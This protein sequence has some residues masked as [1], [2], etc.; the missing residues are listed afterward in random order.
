MLRIDMAATPS[1]I[2]EECAAA[3]SRSRVWRCVSFRVS[4]MGSFSNQRARRAKPFRRFR[5]LSETRYQLISEIN[6]DFDPKSF[7]GNEISV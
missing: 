3:I 4:G 2:I 6:G 1:S 5:V 7:L